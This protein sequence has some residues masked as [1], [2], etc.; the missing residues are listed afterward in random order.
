MTT[1]KTAWSE[2][3]EPIATA[4]QRRALYRLGFSRSIVKTMNIKQADTAIKMGLSLWN[5]L[6]QLPLPQGLAQ[7]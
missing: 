6:R 4:K 5:A 2:V 3:T 1:E 7:S